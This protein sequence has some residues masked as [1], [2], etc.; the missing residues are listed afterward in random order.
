MSAKLLAPAKIEADHGIA[1][2]RK[3][4]TGASA[5]SGSSSKGTWPRLGRR[6][7]VAWGSRHR[8]A[9][10]LAHGTSL[11]D[12]AAT[13]LSSPEF[14]AG[15]GGLAYTAGSDDAFVQHLYATA[16][17]RAA[18]AGGEA[19]WDAQLE[20]G[21]SRVDVALA[22]AL[23]PENEAQLSP[24]FTAGIYVPDATDAAVARL[25]AGL[26]GRVPDGPGLAFW[27]A[28]A[29]GS[30]GLPGV[31]G[32]ILASP[33]G[34][35]HHPSGESDAAFVQQVYADA[36]GRTPE[37]AGAAF[38][39]GH[40]ATYSPAEIALGISESP[41]AQAHLRGQIETGWHLA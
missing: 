4:S 2:D 19:F 23:S 35:A 16:L 30:L 24:T 13:F 18:D 41:E 28:Q 40:L 5:V 31:A 6:A 29:R 10:A 20:S 12:A 25:Y 3:R 32:A 38:W 11:H 14:T 36:L 17:G 9:D 33:E 22:F 21:A 39:T 15:N 1:P 37:P 27:E 7:R 8:Y 34:R 26:L